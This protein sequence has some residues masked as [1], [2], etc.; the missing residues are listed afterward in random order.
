MCLF[1]LAGNIDSIFHAKRRDALATIFSTRHTTPPCDWYNVVTVF[2][3]R[4]WEREGCSLEKSLLPW[5]LD[6]PWRVRSSR[7][8]ISL[9]ENLKSTGTDYPLDRDDI[10]LYLFLSEALPE[11]HTATERLFGKA[12]EYNRRKGL[13][14]AVPASTLRYASSEPGILLQPRG[15]VLNQHF[16]NEGSYARI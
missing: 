13:F 14:V 5:S 9:T 12:K 8:S 7:I 1:S 11:L 2:S 10:G 6:L 4:A 15:N 3:R 16:F